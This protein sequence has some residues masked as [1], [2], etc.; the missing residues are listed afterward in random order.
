MA[1]QTY[2]ADIAFLN[3]H[4]EII[5]LAA[6]GGKVAVAPGWVGRV[7][8]S[9]L[10]GEDAAGFGWLNRP[11]IEAGQTGTPFDNYGGEDRFWLGPEGGQFC[12]W[13]AEGEPFDLAHWKTPPGINEGPFEVVEQSDTAVT[14]TRQ[15]E[16]TN[17]SGARFA[18][19]VERTATALS[20][21][22]AETLLG[23]SVP[24]SMVGFKTENKLTN[25]GDAAWKRE[26]GLLSIWVLGQFVVLPRGKVLVPFVPGP[27][28]KLGK[29]ATLDYFGPLPPERGT[30]ADDHLLFTCD[31]QFRSK[32]GIS[33]QR[34]KD[35]LGSFDPDA[36]VLTI[37]KFNLPENAP[38]RP[39]VNSLWQIHETLDAA[40]S[41]DAVN[42]YN[43][44]PTS[45]HGTGG[46]PFYEI[47]TSSP[48]AQLAPDEAIV[49]CHRTFH[50]AGER[51]ELDAL[52]KAVLGVGLEGVG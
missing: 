16:V 48:A 52:A 15:F 47:E 10:G 30:L 25:A 1:E 33:P 8:T 19:L 4:T 7:M 39:Y 21:A 36:N 34:A 31:G 51:D 5:E 32:I 6:G 38:D 28:E 37:V 18:C 27:E 46:A 22:E 13:F 11:F 44:G 40:Y 24:A 23:A 9:T 26:T 50:F 20:A 35:T 41:G 49:H 42:S 2:A 17:Y 43:D 14:M 45:G 29:R 3:E 12:L